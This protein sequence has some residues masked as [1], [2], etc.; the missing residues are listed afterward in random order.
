MSNNFAR[1]AA[2]VDGGC[3]NIKIYLGNGRKLVRRSTASTKPT[4]SA[5][6]GMNSEPDE[7]V[8]NVGGKIFAVGPRVNDPLDTRFHSYHVSELNLALVAAT[9]MSGEFDLSTTVVDACFGLPLH[10]FYNS[11]GVPQTKLIDDRI[12]A[13]R[14]PL[15]V[16]RGS[17]KLPKDGL[18][19]TLSGAAEGVGA[20][21][22]YRLDEEG[23]S[24]NDPQGLTVIVD[25]GGSTTDIAII[26]E[27]RVLFGGLSSSLESG[28]LGL[29]QRVAE[30]VQ[31]EFDMRVAPTTVRIEDC[32]RE[33]SCNFTSGNLKENIRGI[34]T[35][36]RTAL[37]E[38]IALSVEQRLSKR[39]DE[40]S[41]VLYVGGG[42]ELLGSELKDRKLG[43][44]NS[45]VIEDPQL[46]NARGFYKFA[47]LQQR[48]AS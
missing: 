46:A 16:I 10:K 22:D 8:L 17:K 28:A 33:H 40:V 13:W 25:V 4:V 21:L 38:E 20:Y 47:V 48:H 5:N 30:R 6:L 7:I 39:M 1:I 15:E 31:V 41:S 35:H 42:A 2:G 29:Y 45:V 26:E 9:L 19:G 36:E 12:T 23:N 32:I 24:L 3:N 14:R 37:A 11:A 27:G 44:A 43:R 18:F 34:V